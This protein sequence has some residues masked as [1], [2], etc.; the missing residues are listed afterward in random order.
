QQ[1]V[2]GVAGFGERRIGIG[3]EQDRIR[4]VDAGEPQL[5]Q[6]LRDGVGILSYVGGERHD[7]MAGPL[8]DA[9]DARRPLALED[10]AVLGVGYLLRRILRRLPVR[11]LRTAFNVVDL[12]AIELER[13]A[14]FD[15]RLDL[16]LPR[17]DAVTRR[18]DRL[19]VAGADGGKA[20]A[21]GPADVDH[22]PTG[23]IKLQRTRAPPLHIRP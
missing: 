8:P 18:S 4:P 16:A 21:G 13:D 9:A 7:R 3:A 22:A 1:R 12:L 19:K 5:A 14:Q 20:D 23:E 2:A 6:G 10:G 15:Q 11:V 17:E